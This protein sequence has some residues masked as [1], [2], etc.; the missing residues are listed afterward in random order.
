MVP[1]MAIQIVTKVKR[2]DGVLMPF[3]EKCIVP[4]ARLQEVQYPGYNVWS[5]C[6]A[7]GDAG[8][9]PDAS[10]ACSKLKASDAL[11]AY[12]QAVRLGN[13]AFAQDMQ[14]FVIQAGVPLKYIDEAWV[15]A[16]VQIIEKVREQA[17]EAFFDRF[18]E[19]TENHRLELTRPRA[20]S[21]STIF[22]Q[23][24]M[25][26]CKR[27]QVD[28]SVAGRGVPRILQCQW[29]YDPEGFD[30]RVKFA[31]EPG[32]DAGGP[33]KD[34]LRSLILSV[35]RPASVTD[36]NKGLG[37]L[38]NTKRARWWQRI[39]VVERIVEWKGNR[40]EPMEPKYLLEEVGKYDI[41][42][43]S[44][45]D[46]STKFRGQLG[47]A[48][49]SRFVFL[50]QWLARA[51]AIDDNGVLCPRSLHPVMYDCIAAGEVVTPEFTSLYGE[52]DVI[53]ECEWLQVLRGSY[54][55]I[56]SYGADPS[57][58]GVPLYRSEQWEYFGTEWGLEATGSERPTDE[59][60]AGEPARSFTQRLCSRIWQDKFAAP[61]DAIIKGFNSIIPQDQLSADRLRLESDSLDPQDVN[62]SV[63]ATVRAALTGKQLKLLVEGVDIPLTAD[64]ILEHAM[65][66][67]GWSGKE[68]KLF[69]R[70]VR[71]L[72]SE[73]L[74]NFLSFFTANVREPLGGFSKYPPSFTKINVMRVRGH[75]P[76][77]KAHTCFDTIDV[78]SACLDERSFEEFLDKLKSSILS[79]DYGMA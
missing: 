56:A 33:T 11:D 67:G 3:P 73:E 9:D 22:E 71:R 27:S 28:L 46:T 34:W 64:R 1:G 51:Y 18:P 4:A 57:N 32:I 60:P 16:S 78:P 29:K 35:V 62:G 7:C 53:P 19:S 41:P 63:G 12:Y 74:V 49:E 77:F 61:M 69:T 65:W 17:R 66:K 13:L 59:V 43:W 42:V 36:S 14:E 24:F 52:D 76:L 21:D 23:T 25:H 50:G 2:T 54:S 48:A 72:D 39:G 58:P 75:C 45:L 26:T 30:F 31:G 79:Q 6:Q 20:E 44:S 47:K 5:E 37:T 40:Q 38:A 15:E 55:D 8:F 68:M 70:A 10:P